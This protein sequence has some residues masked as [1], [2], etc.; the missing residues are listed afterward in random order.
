MFWKIIDTATEYDPHREDRSVIINIKY[1]EAITYILRDPRKIKIHVPSGKEWRADIG[2]M[3]VFNKW[4]EK[5]G[6]AYL[7]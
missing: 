5:N 6:I 7:N 2:C 3:D 1:V 4:V